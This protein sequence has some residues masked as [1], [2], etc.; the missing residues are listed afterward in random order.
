[1]KDI[2]QELLKIAT[3]NVNKKLEEERKKT[4]EHIKNEI[5]DVNFILK[6][7]EKKMLYKV[8]GDWREPQEFKMITKE[9]FLKDYTSDPKES[10]HRKGISIKDR[11]L[12][13]EDDYKL[14]IVINNEIEY[15]HIGYIIQDF[16]N[17]LKD[18]MNRI[19]RITE[20]LN[21]LEKHF[22]MLINQEKNIKKFIEDY[23]EIKEQLNKED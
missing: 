15:K 2:E 11:G 14:K 3:E 12:T 10:W 16:T 1:M 19:T 18:K 20:G 22:K 9:I 8:I 7:I 17:E 5:E 21:E 4:E 6:L 13:G 23:N